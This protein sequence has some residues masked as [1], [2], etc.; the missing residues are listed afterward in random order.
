MKSKKGLAGRWIGGIIIVLVLIGAVGYIWLSEDNDGDSDSEITFDLPERIEENKVRESLI[1]EDIGTYTYEKEYSIKAGGDFNYE[2]Y[3]AY[4]TCGEDEGCA[5][6]IIRVYPTAFE[7]RNHMNEMVK[8]GWSKEMIGQIEVYE[9]NSDA[10]RQ[11][12][13]K[14]ASTVINVNGV[15][16]K[17]FNKD[18]DGREDIDILFDSY[19]AKYS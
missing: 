1:L 10:S 9:F 12:I 3:F 7:A 2:R 6:A 8:V 15:N 4:Y 11:F 14:T 19:F 13:W 18:I 5:E 16:L 17:P